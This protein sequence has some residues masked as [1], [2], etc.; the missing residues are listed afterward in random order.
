VVVGFNRK[1]PGPGAAPTWVTEKNG[2]FGL[3]ARCGEI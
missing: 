3:I 1:A 2:R